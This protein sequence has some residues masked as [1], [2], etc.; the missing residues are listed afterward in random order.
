MILIE[1][2][3]VLI[4]WIAVLG[5][6]AYVIG[7]PFTL[8]TYPPITDLPVH[9]VDTSIVRHYFDPSFHFREQFELH[10][11][12]LPYAAEYFLGA[13]F[14][15]FVS[16]S[17]AT[18]LTA[19]V[20]LSLLPVGLAVFFHGMKKSPLWGS[21]GLGFVWCT[22]THWGFLNFM[23]AIGLYAMSAGFTLLVVDRPC[24][25]RQLGLGVTLV[26]IF[27]THF[28]RFP[29]ALLTVAGITVLMYPATR[30]WKPVLP[31]LGGAV[32]LFAVWWAF[33]KRPGLSGK[34]G[35]LS[36]HGDRLAQIPGYLF[37]SFSGPRE[38]VVGKQML[39]VALGLFALTALAFFIQGRHRGRS[40]R[41]RWWGVGVTLVPVL[42]GAAFLLAY[43]ILPMDLGSWWYVYPRE[44]TTAG[45]VALA[46]M[47]DLPKAWWL[48]LPLLA[49]FAIVSGRMA[50]ITATEWHTFEVSTKDFRAI[51]AEIPKAPKLMYLVFDHGGTTRTISPYVHL[52]AWVQAEKGGWSSWS[53]AALGDVHPIRFR[54]GGNV[55]PAVPY[56][57]EWTPE[58]FDLQTNGAFFDTFLVRDVGSPE[59]LFASDPSIHLAASQGGWW[60]YRREPVAQ[61]G[62]R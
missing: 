42:M 5:V 41:E 6:A 12:E 18:K 49:A 7:Y 45:Y 21:L 56:R 44:V 47:P 3:R 33:F 40:V 43:L 31:P 37:G 52:P 11:L 62:T 39:W 59:R 28:Y 15:L 27:F 60:L 50:L 9:A 13:F 48:R 26:A 17:W 53:P 24:R 23:G 36:L 58:K 35:R 55:P 22:L 61:A 51:I 1:R 57:W 34:I 19:A 10:F 16:I 54:A 32:A 30:T 4:L 14:A 25:A 46:A 2:W 29:F 20:M 38:H 8:A